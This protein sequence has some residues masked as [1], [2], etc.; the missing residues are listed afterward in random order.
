[1]ST[2]LLHEYTIFALWV[3]LGMVGVFFAI[4]AFRTKITWGKARLMGIPMVV[5]GWMTFIYWLVLFE[6]AYGI[7]SL[8]L[9]W[10]LWIDILLFLVIFGMVLT[11]YLRLLHREK[12]KPVLFSSLF[13][14]P[15]SIPG[16]HTAGKLIPKLS[17]VEKLTPVAVSTPSTS[18]LASSPS[19]AISS[20]VRKPSKSPVAF[21]RRILIGDSG[22]EV[23]F[24]NPQ[25]MGRFGDSL[26]A[27]RL[28]AQGYTKETSKVDD[29]HGIDGVYVR[30]KS[31]KTPQKII[32]VE[33]KAGSGRLIGDRMT[34]MWVNKQINKMLDHSDHKVRRT[35]ELIRANP[36]LVDKQLWHY[37]LYS[38]KTTI[39]SLDAEAKKISRDM[40][41]SISNLV[42]KSCESKKPSIRCFPADG[43]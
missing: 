25:A 22:Y 38:G 1:M 33:N 3:V 10:P 5:F 6:G 20:E 28:T 13:L 12:F 16:I 26:T 15:L 29:I 11:V 24:S 7:A 4:Q 19:A 32:I 14:I 40:G 18:S 35:G 31:N 37:D 43:A 2:Y 34:D 9:N 42:R 21:P 36:N 23:E 39:S 41:I 30:Y 8:I 27:R 17:F